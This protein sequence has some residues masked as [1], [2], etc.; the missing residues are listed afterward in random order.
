MGEQK[1]SIPKG[2]RKTKQREAILKVL[3]RAE[4]PINAEQIF[5]ELKNNGIDISLSTIYRNL[6]MLTK[7]GLVVKSYMM[8]EDKARFALPDKKNYLVC[9]KCGKIVI[10]DNCPFDKFK[11]ELIEVHGFDITGHSIEVYGVCPECQKKG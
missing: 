7:E 8:N 4:Y 5:M 9:E 3:E 2:Y 6:E 10:I 1:L 11:E